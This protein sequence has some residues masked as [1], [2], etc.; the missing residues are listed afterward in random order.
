MLV[1]CYCTAGMHPPLDKPH[2]SCQSVIDALRECHEGNPRMK[3]LGSCNAEKAA[4]DA[5]FKR[6]KQER[7]AANRAVAKKSR[8]RWEHKKAEIAARRDAEGGQ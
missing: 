1:C 8:A 3:F 5:C 2:P 4:L 6:E 7:R